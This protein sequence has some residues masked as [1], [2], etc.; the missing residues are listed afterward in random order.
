MHVLWLKC[1]VILGIVFYDD[2]NKNDPHRTICLRTYFQVGG[3]FGEGLG[4]LIF[5]ECI[6][7]QG[8]VIIFQKTHNILSYLSLAW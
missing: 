4:S 1:H 2:L 8:Q 7:Y 5:L 6:C 3:T